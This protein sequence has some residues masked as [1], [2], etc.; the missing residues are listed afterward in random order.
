MI[1]DNENIV[2]KQVTNVINN[3]N[4]VSLFSIIVSFEIF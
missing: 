3:L 2:K 1:V 4:T